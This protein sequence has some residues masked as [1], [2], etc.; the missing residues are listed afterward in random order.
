MFTNSA[1]GY[2][3]YFL[4]NSN[5]G[6]LP[7]GNDGTD[8]YDRNIAATYGDP[9]EYGTLLSNLEEGDT[10]ISYVSGQGYRAVGT[11]TQE[12]D[13]DPVEDSDLWIDPYDNGEYH[14]DVQWE[15]VL[16]EEEAIGWKEGNR[17]LGY[18]EDTPVN[19]TLKHVDDPESGRRL[20]ELMRRERQPDPDLFLTP[21]GSKTDNLERT[22]ENPVPKS[23]IAEHGSRIDLSQ[24]DSETVPVWGH[25]EDKGVDDG[26]V[27]LFYLDGEYPYSGVVAD[28]ESN[29]SLA[30]DIWEPFGDDDWS[31]IYYMTDVRKLDAP[32]EEVAAVLDNDLDYPYPMGFMNPN[33]EKL[34]LLRRKFGGVREFVDYLS[35][36]IADQEPTS[37]WSGIPEQYS[38]IAEQLESTG[39]VIFHGPPGTGK[40]YHANRFADWWVHEDVGTVQENQQIRFITFHPSFSYEDFIEGLTAKSEDGDITYDLEDGVFKDYIESVSYWPGQENV[41][42]ES[43]DGE[44]RYVLIIDEINRGNVSNILGETVTLLE[45]DK[46]ADGDNATSVRL[47]HS[48]E[49]FE[50][51]S[52][53]YLIGTMNTADRSI[54]LVDAAI[55]RRFGFVHFPPDYEVLQRSFKLDGQ[56]LDQLAQRDDLDGLQA[57]SIL[58]LE[59]I[60]ETIRGRR[61]LGKGKQLGHSYLLGADSEQAIVRAWKYELLPLLEEYFF[62]SFGEIANSVFD[63]PHTH[64]ILDLDYEEIRT[65]FGEETD[66][67]EPAALRTVLQEVVGIEP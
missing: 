18:P 17:A 22:I 30:D 32:V 20:V 5:S 12:W 54:S 42:G 27:F 58:A 55:R 16:G 31:Y 64:Y 56:D 29:P 48:N 2:V 53:V 39:Q 43:Y 34:A 11:V 40:T 24:F 65:V 37:D 61:D 38:R 15:R 19:Y 51:P 52:N 36:G 6:N 63:A 45:S 14:I 7:K 66:I 50:I 25:T 67:E 59:D 23:V 33:P 44:P 1:Y 3:G 10:V 46:R 35:T 62:D 26:D 49:E 21:A 4:L 47:A 41:D 28:Q 9:D 8:I 60:N 57:L 13:G